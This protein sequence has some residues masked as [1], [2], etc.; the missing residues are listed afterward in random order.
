MPSNIKN[1]EQQGFCCAKFEESHLKLNW[2]NVGPSAFASSDGITSLTISGGGSFDS[3]AFLDSDIETVTVTT[4]CMW[5]QD[6]SEETPHISVWFNS[7]CFIR[8]NNNRI[9]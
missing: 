7:Y 8:W 3:A 6:P 4:D 5:Y 9:N 1:I 2:C